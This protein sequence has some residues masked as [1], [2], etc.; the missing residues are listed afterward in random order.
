MIFFLGTCFFYSM[1]NK[2]KKSFKIIEI[3]DKEIERK[4]T[5]FLKMKDVNN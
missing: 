5:Q 1:K 4:Q 2:N 3:C